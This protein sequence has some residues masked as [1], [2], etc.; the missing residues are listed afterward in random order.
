MRVRINGIELGEVLALAEYSAVAGSGTVNG[1][2]PFAWGDGSLTMTNG[3]LVGIDPGGVIRYQPETGSG[4]GTGNESLDLV[5]QALSNYHYETLEA[6][7][8]YAPDG[9]LLLNMR[10][11]GFNPDLYDGQRVN[12]N[13]NLS[14]NIPS[15]LRSLQAGRRVADLVAKKVQ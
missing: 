10:I 3:T 15:L 1:E 9:E 8:S 2:F 6:G 4:E 11:E 5:T 13:L 14:D 7:A 12:L